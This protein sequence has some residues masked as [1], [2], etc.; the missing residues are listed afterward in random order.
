MSPTSAGKK[1]YGEYDDGILWD[2]PDIGVVWPLGLVGGR[3]GVIL[4]EKDK[5]L[6]SFGE[7]MERYGGF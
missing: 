6:Q 3:E 1:F 7:F 4:A 5:K 2:D